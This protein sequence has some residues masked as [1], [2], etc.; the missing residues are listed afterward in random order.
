M[1]IRLDELD[2]LRGL[3][4]LTVIMHHYLLIFPVMLDETFGKQ[5]YGVINTI[6]Y[7]PFHVFFAGHE[8][9]ILFFV[10]SGFVLSLPYLNK[11]NLS[12]PVYLSKRVLRL[13]I[14]YIVS[15]MLAILLYL[16]FSSGPIEGLSK[17]F[18]GVWELPIHLTDVLQHFFMLGDFNNG[19]FNPIYW[20][21][22]H[23]MRISIIFPVVMFLLV[24][25]NWKL[26]V[27]VSLVISWAAFIGT[28]LLVG[29]FKIDVD[30]LLTVY[31][32]F[33]FIVGALLAKHKNVFINIYSKSSIRVKGIY[34]LFSILFYTFSWWGHGIPV[35]HNRLI[36]DFVTIIGAAMMIIISIS[37]IRIK[38][39]LL[40]EPIHFIGKISYSLYLYHCIALFTLMHLLHGKLPVIFVLILSFL[41]TT[42]LSTL[43]Y[44]FVEL[45]SIRLGKSITKKNVLE[46]KAAS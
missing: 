22:V 20:S 3:A 32:L 28:S 31:Y 16:C 33:M 18:N 34:V 41:V 7:S 30:Y 42:I 39:I 24:K 5:G 46:R 36:T 21:L 9:V 8:A 13:Y 19:E 40:L 1:R 17:W 35:L 10:L 14:P 11:S 12:Y 2:S 25:Y 23:E 26:T 29:Y 44:Y 37:S 45:P 43:S 15:V 27:V 6:K 38:N 4:A